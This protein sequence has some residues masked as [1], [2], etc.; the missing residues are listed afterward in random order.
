MEQTAFLAAENNFV[1]VKTSQKNFISYL[2]SYPQG[3]NALNAH[4]ALAEIY[5]EGSEREAALEHYQKL[6][7][8][9]PNEY[10]EQALVR[11]TQVLVMKDMHME[12]EDLWRELEIEAV[13]PENKRYAKFNL[14]RSYYQSQN[15]KESQAKA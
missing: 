15:L 3:R 8:N 11:A 5:F 9:K 6:I 1:T 2:E 12:A 7:D 4:F 13:Y 14:M 10:Y